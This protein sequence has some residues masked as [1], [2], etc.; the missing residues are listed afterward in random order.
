MLNWIIDASLRHRFA[1]IA[2]VAVVAVAGILSLQHLDI[3]AF[4]DT[5]PV[6]V[7]VNTTAPSLLP[8]EVERQITFPVEQAISGLPGLEQLRFR[9]QVWVF[10]SNCGFRRWNRHL[11][12]LGSWWGERLATVELPASIERPKM[13]PV[14]SGLGE[15]FHYIVTYDGYDFSTLNAEERVSKLT[16]LRTLHDWTIKPQLRTVPGTAEVNTW[17]GYEKQY[18]VRI[19]PARLIRHGLTFE[20][21]VSAL[22]RNNRSVGG[23]NI[24]RSSEMLLVHGQ[25]RTVNEEEIGAIVVTAE[26]GVPVRVRDVGEVVLGY[27]V[28]RGA[29]TADGNG[30]SVMGLGFCLMGE[31]TSEVTEGLKRKMEDIRATLPPGVRLI[32]MYDRTEL[33][34]HVIETVRKNLFEGGLF[35][36]A[37]LFVFLGNLRAGLIVALAIPLSMLCAFFRDA[38]FRHCRKPS[39]PGSD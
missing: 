1:V 22:Q 23:G 25:G 13:G 5:T 11:L 24:L 16:E 28:R 9:I 18:Q 39:E 38:P 32:S 20:Q 29:V 37:V 30:E 31:N 8:E 21:V 19:D 2:L 6:Q 10:A 34:D 17:G 27:E 3:D 7:Q 15:V 26:H 36:V 35:V 14:A 4:P 33:V 12:R